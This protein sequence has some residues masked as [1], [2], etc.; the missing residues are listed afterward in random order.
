[1]KRLCPKKAVRLA[2]RAYTRPGRRW[3]RVDLPSETV[4]A[5]RGTSTPR[6]LVINANLVGEEYGGVRFHRGWLHEARRARA[7]LLDS[8]DL[9]AEVW[10]TG[11]SSGGA[12]AVILAYLLCRDGGVRARAVTFGCPPFVDSREGL[13][14]VSRA[15][16]LQNYVTDGDFVSSIPLGVQVADSLVLQDDAPDGGP[17][18]PLQL[19]HISTYARLCSRW[20]R[21]SA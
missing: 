1:M 12:I 4:L 17:L 16:E 11:H 21:S 15:V 6:D 5:V 14:W 10:C 20:S 7:E 13:Q 18:R 9:P 19:H 3:Q 2:S 8:G